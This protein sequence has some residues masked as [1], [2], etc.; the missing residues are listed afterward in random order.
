MCC[1]VL[2]WYRT[3]KELLYTVFF[4]VLI[5]AAALRK[6]ETKMKKLYCVY[7]SIEAAIAAVKSLM[8]DGCSAYRDG[9]KVFIDDGGYDWGY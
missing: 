1:K 8:A 5:W 4:I 6:G 3:V 2:E 9:F 7:E